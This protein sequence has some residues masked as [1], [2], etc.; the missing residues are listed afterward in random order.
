MEH[1][2]RLGVWACAESFPAS[3]SAEL[4][5][6]VFAGEVLG[7]N[8]TWRTGATDPDENLST[9][10]LTWHLPERTDTV[11]RQRRRVQGTPGYNN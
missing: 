3:G 4:N 10:T 9:Q 8:S 7:I 6:V 2:R 1:S 11:A 5:T